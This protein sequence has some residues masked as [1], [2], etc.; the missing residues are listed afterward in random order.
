MMI[1]IKKAKW[2]RIPTIVY[3]AH[4]STTVIPIIAH[5]AFTDFSKAA[6]G[7]KTDKER[8]TLIAI[9][10]PYLIMPVMLLF[11][12]IGLQ[13]DSPKSKTKRH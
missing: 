9:Y 3:A 7:P 8:Y 1:G 4:V 13:F 2:I 12:M 10:I 6:F 5:V 11:Y